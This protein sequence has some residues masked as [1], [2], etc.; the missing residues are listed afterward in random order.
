VA[1]ARR[2]RHPRRRA[3]A[4]GAIAALA[5]LVGTSGC[6]PMRDAEQN[7]HEA[8][9]K[10][11]KQAVILDEHRNDSALTRTAAVTLVCVDPK[12]L[13]H[14]TDAFGALLY[15]DARTK[16]AVVVGITPGSIADKAYLKVED[17][18]YEFGGT[19]IGSAAELR[20]AVLAVPNGQQVLIKFHRTRYE[21]GAYAQ[22]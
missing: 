1:E 20:T 7:A 8:C 3:L 14:T 19:E 17:V 9:A 2:T 15:A 11:G 5:I 4:P 18:I 6:D 16:G 12:D 10:Q 22:F 21:R 13:V